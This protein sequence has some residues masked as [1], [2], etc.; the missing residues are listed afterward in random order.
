M[1]A[2][3]AIVN[4]SVK[5]TWNLWLDDERNPGLAADPSEPQVSGWVWAKSTKEAI[6][7]VETLGNPAFMSLDHDLGGDDTSMKFLKWLANY[8]YPSEY[9]VHSANP[10][11]AKNIVS[12]MESWKKSLLLK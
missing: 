5:V 1:N 3:I 12:F 10:V 8:S 4:G 6:K 7:L 9:Q 2:H 11:G